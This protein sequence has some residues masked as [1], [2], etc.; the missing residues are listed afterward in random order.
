MSEATVNTSEFRHGYI[1]GV[2]AGTEARELEDE[3]WKEWIAAVDQ[4]SKT[5]TTTAAPHP[6]EFVVE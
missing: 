1:T 5:D 4:W 6:R 2:M 3:N